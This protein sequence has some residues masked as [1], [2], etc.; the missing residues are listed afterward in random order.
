MHDTGRIDAVYRRLLAR[1]AAADER[2]V[3]LAALDRSRREFGAD[4]DSADQLLGVGESKR[5]GGSIPW[6][7]PPG[8]A[9]RWP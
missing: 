7:T 4:P 9:S 1:P 6:S 3:L 8:R 5:D 2:E